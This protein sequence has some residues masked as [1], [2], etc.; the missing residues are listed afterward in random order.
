MAIFEYNA[1]TAA[2]RLMKGTI[3][4]GSAQE[5]GE[6]LGQMQ[7]T[8][9]SVE[10]VKVSEPH[11][12]I[13]RSEFLL[14]NQ[15]LASITK[16]GIPLERG[17]RELSKD[18]ASKKM[19]EMITAVVEDLE[20]GVSVEEAFGKREKNFPPLYGR[21]LKA[22]IETGR[23]SQMLTNL[24]RHL[25]TAGQTRRIIFEAIAYPLV[26][27]VLAS[28]IASGVLIF[29][30][31]QFKTIVTEMLEG[32]RMNPITVMIF[33][34]SEN[35]I[36]FWI[37]LAVI[38][39]AIAG[40]W[41]ILSGFAAGRRF[42][43]AVILKIPVL[44]RLYHTSILS[45]M[46]E[47]M[48]LMTAAGCDMPTMLRLSAQAS[49]SEKIIL[50]NEM[51]AEQIEQGA[52]IVE[53]GQ[54]CRVVPRLF[55]YSIQMGSQRNELADNLYSLAQ[56]YFE[57]GRCYQTRLQ[58]ILLPVMLIMVGLFILTTILAIFLPMI[59]IVTGLSGS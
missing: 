19:R 2:G 38:V 36:W 46:A 17:L 1:L 15:Q 49:G 53:A 28:V 20:K 30:V 52:N 10:K 50:E 40:L 5:A 16:A 14:F 47:S 12:S 39:A 23:L 13:G 3:E 56:M 4:A 8:V 51:L 9:N 42:K 37:G 59:Q 31:P 25:E 48:S 35:V 7:L 43:E 24:N 18:I 11:T 21:I 34:M 44:G 55:L 58:T 26:I 27:F 45:R 22:G 33:A 57:Q 41:G 32:A 29:I 54:F 6:L